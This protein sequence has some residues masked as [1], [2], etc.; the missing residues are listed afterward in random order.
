MANKTIVCEFKHAKETKGA[1]QYKEPAD[2]FKV[3]TI[4]LRKSALC[5][6]TPDTITA[7]ITYDA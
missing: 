7:T 1:H 6:D 2:D 3:G 5:G 4:Y